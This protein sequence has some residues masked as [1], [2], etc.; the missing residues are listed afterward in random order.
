MKLKDYLEDK[1]LIIILNIGLMILSGVYLYFC[2][3]S[4]NEILIYLVIWIFVLFLY[5]FVNWIKRRKYFNKIYEILKDLDKSYLISEIMPK[6]Y[7]LE[8]NLNRDILKIS[9][10]SV[11]DEINYFKKDKEEYKEFIESWIHEVKLPI[12]AINLICDNNK[13]NITRKIKYEL[14]NIENDVEKALFY[15]RSDNV[16][17]DYIIRKINLKNMVLNVIQRNRNFLISNNMNINI[18]INEEYVYTD[19]KWIEFILTQLILNSVKY[20]NIKN[21]KIDFYAKREKSKTKLIIE[22]NG[23]G[24]EKSELSRVFNKGF[25]GTNGRN[26]SNSTGIG[27]Y[28]SKKL[29]RKLGI[30][31]DIQS[32]KDSYTRVI[33][34]FPDGSEHFSR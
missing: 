27:L 26:N 24:I 7:N 15:S 23:L 34:E 18:D 10:K 4:K 22:D 21:P 25:T 33:I 11:I 1:L 29:S 32:K 30:F 28:L 20:K 6:S 19:D 2:N 17:K 8:D 12:T 5:L 9:N 31:M 3:V 14:A 13:S 16:Y